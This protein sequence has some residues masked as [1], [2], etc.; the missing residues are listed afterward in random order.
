MGRMVS[1]LLRKISLCNLPAPWV[2]A[3]DTLGAGDV[4]HGAFALGL[5]EGKSEREAIRFSNSVAALKCTKFGGQ[6]SIPT[7]RDINK[8]INSK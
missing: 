2:K 6:S 4:W 5:A 3:E 7:R 8:F 1:T